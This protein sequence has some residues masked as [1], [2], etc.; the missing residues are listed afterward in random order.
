MRSLLT[1]LLLFLLLTTASLAQAIN[2]H[3]STAVLNQ[4]LKVERTDFTMQGRLLLYTIKPLRLAL[5]IDSF[6]GDP[7]R[8]VDLISRWS[9]RVDG[10]KR[11]RAIRQMQIEQGLV[12]LAEQHM[13]WRADTLTTPQGVIRYFQG[14]YKAGSWQGKLGSL[15]LNKPLPNMAL[16][17]SIFPMQLLGIAA[18][19]S[20]R[21][22]TATLEQG[23]VPGLTLQKLK[24]TTQAR[25]SKGVLWQLEGD[26]GQLE[27]MPIWHHLQAMPQWQQGVAWRIRSLGVK[28]LTPISGQFLLSKLK[29]EGPW[30]MSPTEPLKQMQGSA[31]WQAQELAIRVGGGE[32]YGLRKGAEQLQC[33]TA[34]GSF[35]VEGG[36]LLLKAWQGV[37]QLRGGEA[38]VKGLGVEQL[39]PPLHKPWRYRVTQQGMQQPPWWLNPDIS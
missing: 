32:A 10:L 21:T 22:G 2:W 1:L 34:S 11:F 3:P 5:E 27:L 9:G 29:L 4:R 19:G 12:R 24:L 35:E 23:L 38:K 6:S 7:Q 28:E 20:G 30:P 39:Y 14:S 25:S 33:R 17:P 13:E 15:V 18:K 37:V 26:K 36:R 31:Q 8:I 16:P